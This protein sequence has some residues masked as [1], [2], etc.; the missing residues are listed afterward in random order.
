M[1]GEHGDRAAALQL[2]VAG[3]S[4]ADLRSAL[5]AGGVLLNA[6]AETLLAHPAFDLR[7]PEAVTLVE[8]SLAELGLVGGGTLPEVFAA[9]ADRGLDLCPPDTAPYL[10]L[11]M[12]WQ[13]NALDSVLSAGRSP[14][15]ALKV[16]SAP[17]SEEADYP[18]GFYLRVVDRRSW[19]RGYRCDLE[20]LFAPEDR[21]AFRIRPGS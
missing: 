13:E 4:R 14:A 16:A 9:A 15:G 20:Y 17:L 1:G 8:R 7:A 2:E 11:A 5:D 12:T 6:H 18:K 10:R 21:F 19:L 3:L